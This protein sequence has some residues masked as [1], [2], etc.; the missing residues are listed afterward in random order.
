M[1]RDNSISI[2]SLGLNSVIC[3]IL[4]VQKSSRENIAAIVRAEK[5]TFWCRHTQVAVYSSKH[6][7]IVTWN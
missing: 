3:I 2:I 5:N 4:I 1:E 6:T 7:E